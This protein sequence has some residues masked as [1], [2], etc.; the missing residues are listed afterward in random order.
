M[1]STSDF[2]RGSSKIVY[3][4]EPWL[5]IEFG[6][7]KPGKGGAYVKTKLRNI[8]TGSVLDVT[9]RSGEKL[10]E[11]DLVASNMQFL[12]KDDMFHFLD[13]ETY[14]QVDLSLESVGKAADY[15]KD[16]EICK[17]LYLDGNPLS[18]E[19]P[20]FVILEIVDT[21]PGVK[22][23]TAQG[24]SKPATLETGLIIQIPLFI[25]E[26]EKIKIDTRDNK[27]IER[28]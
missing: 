26:G 2:R 8:K 18:V 22:G 14:E 13:Q 4:G 17:V 12:Y 20:T 27:Y 5:V 11:P 25:S 23:N 16:G 21:V 24:G 10:E 3:K 28:A 6:S 19:A 15:L 7:V 1:I 9:F